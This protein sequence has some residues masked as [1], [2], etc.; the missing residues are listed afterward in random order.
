MMA[1][2]RLVFENN[3]GVFNGES[4]FMFE[5]R[6]IAFY[7]FLNG[8]FDFSTHFNENSSS[9]VYK[10]GN[11]ACADRPVNV[12][13]RLEYD[14]LG[15]IRRV[16]NTF[17]NYDRMNRVVRIG[18][19]AM[20]YQ[21]NGLERIGGMT[22]VYDRRGNLLRTFGC[23]LNDRNF[24]NASGFSSGNYYYGSATSNSNHVSYVYKSGRK[25]IPSDE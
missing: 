17:I 6:G 9:Y 1:N 4:P 3:R 16:G 22:I 25:N 18:N 5:Q 11:S 10:R 2:E 13:V 23:I 14:H 8:D 12:G 20:Q 15:R 24:Q 7:V 19:V 21:R